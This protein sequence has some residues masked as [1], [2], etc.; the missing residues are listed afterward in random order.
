MALTLQ[1]QPS[2]TLLEPVLLQFQPSSER[3][4]FLPASCLDPFLLHIQ[5]G[6]TNVNVMFTSKEF[7]SEG[8]WGQPWGEHQ[9][10]KL[11]Q[12]KPFRKCVFYP[13]EKRISITFPSCPNP[14]N[15]L[16]PQQ[17]D[18]PSPDTEESALP[19]QLS[20]SWKRSVNTRPTLWR[21]QL[22][23]Y[24]SLFEW[25]ECK[26]AVSSR[27]QQFRSNGFLAHQGRGGCGKDFILAAVWVIRRLLILLL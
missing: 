18:C 17:S 8:V 24:S 16:V 11:S 2:T 10:G 19:N 1:C 3:G 15:G 5:E 26:G 13:S 22:L 20:D 23:L 4:I 25:C 7:R 6:E 12:W 21:T 9:W 27:A 14:T